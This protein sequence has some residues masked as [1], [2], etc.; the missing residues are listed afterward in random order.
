MLFDS[1]LTLKAGELFLASNARSDGSASSAAGL[2][3]RDTRFL[4]QFDL[5][6]DGA[7]LELLSASADTLDRAVLHLTNRAG[8]GD[9]LRAHTIAVLMNVV[10]A[11]SMAIDLAITNFSNAPYRGELAIETTSDFRDLFDVRGFPRTTRGE[12]LP[13]RA[14]ALSARLEYRAVDGETVATGI[15]ASPDET[16][17][18][19]ANGEQVSVRF[20]IALEAGASSAR[21]IVITPRPPEVTRAAAPAPVPVSARITTGVPEFDRILERAMSDLAGLDTPFPEGTMPAAGIPWFVAPFGRDSLIVGLQTLHLRPESALGTLQVLATLQGREVVPE[22]EE[23]PGKILHEMRYG[24][25]AR[26][27]EIP[28]RPY[29]GTV[30]ATP[31]F[32]WLVAEAA[33]W[34]GDAAVWQ[35]FKPHA[36]R[37]LQW[38][39]EYGDLDGDGLIEYSTATQ[40]SAHISHKVW[41]DSHDSLHYPDGRPVTGL[42]AAVEVQGYLF[43]AY[44]RLAV[45]AGHFG[46][47]QWAERL[48]E[49]AA[50]VRQTVESQFWLEDE[51]YYAQALNGEKQPIGSVS[52]NPGHLLFAGLPA[53]E[54]AQR[55]AARMISPDLDSGLGL[56]TLSAA[57]ASYNPMSYHNGSVWPHDNSLAIAGLYR[58]GL[59]SEGARLVAGL[60]AAANADPKL[61][62]PELY[63]G[64][65]REDADTAPVAYPVSCSPQ[66]WAAGALPLIVRAM[67]GLEFDL[68]AT[69]V[70]A[71]PQLPDWLSEVE[72]EGLRVGGASG[73]LAIRRSGGG[74]DISSQGLPVALIER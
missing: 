59:A 61:R 58:Y 20:P 1:D 3:L 67:L 25:M 36:E 38:C 19:I 56:R 60:L 29:Y 51:G 41:K 57:S 27:R 48:R 46:D 6:L 30:D 33:L 39:E 9:A 71:S 34:T 68:D 50:A 5:T 73:E 22:T 74:Y 70:T 65:P 8:E 55:V 54:R 23:E 31:L 42:I 12:I 45:A 24:E 4:S 69:R 10:L 49:R 66:A 62:L 72:I 37:A 18:L 63:C 2:Y 43:A 14:A 53:P 35:R 21:R 44:D 17:E 11:G 28:H 13:A 26:T 47:A 7:P 40:S 64:F 16:A 52:S 15:D 32:A